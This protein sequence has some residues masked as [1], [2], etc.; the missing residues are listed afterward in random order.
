MMEKDVVEASEGPVD[1]MS[2]VLTRKQWPMMEDMRWVTLDAVM[3][4]EI[5][6]KEEGKK[7]SVVRL[8]GSWQVL[9]GPA[10]LSNSDWF[11]LLTGRRDPFISHRIK[12]QAA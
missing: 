1:I 2:P 9:V 8:S 7:R 6:E 5:R 10:A 3:H 11:K 4:R 12:E